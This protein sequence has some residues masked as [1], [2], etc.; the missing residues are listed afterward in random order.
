MVRP[1]RTKIKG[2]KT[3]T[4]YFSVE[5]RHMTDGP[6]MATDDPHDMPSAFLEQPVD[7]ISFYTSY[8]KRYSTPTEN[9]VLLN[10]NSGLVDVRC[11]RRNPNSR[12][13]RS[14]KWWLSSACP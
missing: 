4:F 5:S 13:V 8:Q 12:E 9:S 6:R 2:M 10:G 7:I 3:G 11:V 14:L 1:G